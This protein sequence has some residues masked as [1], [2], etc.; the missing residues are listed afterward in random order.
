[1]I[2]LEIMYVETKTIFQKILTNLGWEK[3]Y[4]FVFFNDLF[5]LLL[6]L[7]FV[8]NLNQTLRKVKTHF[9]AKTVGR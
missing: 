6:V 7:Q 5:K 1:M 9:G 3:P 8:T 4:A 2:V